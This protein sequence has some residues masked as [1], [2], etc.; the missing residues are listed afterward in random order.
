MPLRTL[1]NLKIEDENNDILYN[2]FGT[3][4]DIFTIP[5]A[6]FQ[7]LYMETLRRPLTEI[8]K[9]VCVTVSNQKSLTLILN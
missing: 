7:V 4:S 1:K 5:T 2:N 3:D 9:I 6:Y 8:R